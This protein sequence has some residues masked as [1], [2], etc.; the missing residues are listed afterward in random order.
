MGANKHEE[1]LRFPCD[2]VFKD[3]KCEVDFLLIVPFETSV[4]NKANL[5]IV[6]PLCCILIF[7]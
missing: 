7:S 6:K 4:R 1:G 5:S 2:S 3:S